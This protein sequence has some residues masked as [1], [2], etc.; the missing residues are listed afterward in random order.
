[1]ITQNA[2]PP[3]RPLLAVLLLAALGVFAL[4]DAQT[5]ALI[6]QNPLLGPRTGAAS[7]PGVKVHVVDADSGA[8]V[9]S[10]V[11]RSAIGAEFGLLPPSQGTTDANGNVIVSLGEWKVNWLFLT[12]TSPLYYTRGLEWNRKTACVTA[13]GGRS[14]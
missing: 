13:L 4:T 9:D 1:M 12:A 14:A 8:P 7:G 2:R 11:V 10:A 6:K 3:A 5:T